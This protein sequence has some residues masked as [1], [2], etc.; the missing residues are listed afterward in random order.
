MPLNSTTMANDIKSALLAAP[1]S[2]AVAGPPLDLLVAAIADA[3]VNRIKAD[4]LV[5]PTLLISPPGIAGGP[6]TGT[7]TII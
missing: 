5:I 4:A 7:G 2:G 6:V 1:G 3:V